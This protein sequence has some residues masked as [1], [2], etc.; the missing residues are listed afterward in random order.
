MPTYQYACTECGHAFEQ[1]QSFTDDALTDAR[2]ATAG[3]ARCSTPSAWS[4]RAPASTAPTAGASV[5][6]PCRGVDV[7]ASPRRRRRIVARRSSDV[8]LGVGVLVGSSSD[9]QPAARP[10]SLHSR[11]LPAALH[12]PLSDAGRGRRALLASRACPLLR[13]LVRARRPSAGAPC[14]AA[15]GCSRRSVALVAVLGRAAGRRGAAAAT[16]A[17]H[18]RRPRP[19]WPARCCGP[20]DVITAAVRARH[21]ARRPLRDPVGRQLAA[22]LRRGQP[23]TDAALVGAPLVATGPTWSRCRSGCPTRRWPS[24][25]ASATRWTWWRPIPRAARP[26]P[27]RATLPCS[28][29]RRP[30]PTRPP[31]ASRAAGGPRRARGDVTAVSSASVTHFLTRRVVPLAWRASAA[32]RLS[33]SRGGPP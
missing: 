7:R 9:V 1:V 25:S 29:C 8:V 14:C 12:S 27:W 6:E 20:D 16:V 2:S 24:C 10:R 11:P 5:D 33:T 4:S 17:G 13:R 28:R 26:R 3:C 22:P 30:R 21:R 15:V 23:V 18:R 19:R 32:R 31:T